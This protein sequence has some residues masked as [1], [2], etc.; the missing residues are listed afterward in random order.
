MSHYFQIIV[1]AIHLVWIAF[2][3]ISMITNE[4]YEP[5]TENGEKGDDFG[6]WHIGNSTYV[7]EGSGVVQNISNHQM[8]S[9]VSSQS[10]PIVFSGC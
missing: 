6:F 8:T 10:Q 7:D 1:I 3:V 4:W 2:T 9:Q 5:E